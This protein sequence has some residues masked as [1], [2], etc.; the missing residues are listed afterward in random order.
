[1]IYTLEF[2]WVNEDGGREEICRQWQTAASQKVIEARARAT[3]RNVVLGGRRSNLC[4]VKDPR[5]KAVS[6]VVGAAN[7]RRNAQ[8]ERAGA[9]AL[10]DRAT[11]PSA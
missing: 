3:I 7:R 5:G 10:V 9:N 1:V 8:R 4:I 6:T 2:Y 11:A